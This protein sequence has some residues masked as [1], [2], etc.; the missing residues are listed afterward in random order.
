MTQKLET[1]ESEKQK[2]MAKVETILQ[3]HKQLRDKDQ[4]FL[5]QVCQTRDSL[6]LALQEK[7]QMIEAKENHIFNLSQSI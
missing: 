2:Y 4:Q 7:D 1:M 5:Q 3:E 6:T